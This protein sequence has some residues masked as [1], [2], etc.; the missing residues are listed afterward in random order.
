MKISIAV[1]KSTENPI[2]KLFKVGI[3]KIEIQNFG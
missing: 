2:S 3:Q 1:E